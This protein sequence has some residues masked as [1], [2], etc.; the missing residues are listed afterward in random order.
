MLFKALVVFSP[1][2]WF[3]EVCSRFC[4]SDTFIYFQGKQW[5]Q[6][7]RQQQTEPAVSAGRREVAH[8]QL[9]GRVLPPAEPRPQLGAF[10][11]G[12]HVPSRG[13][14]LPHVGARRAAV[15]PRPARTP[16]PAPRLVAGTADF[17]PCGSRLVRA[18]S[19]SI[20]QK[21]RLITVSETVSNS[22]H[23]WNNTI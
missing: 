11:P 13:L 14:V 20:W 7:Q 17:Q 22:P 1:G 10:A 19:D 23:I 4:W 8:V 2:L 12:E 15:G 5:K 21:E 6:Q 18:T 3:S 9:G 16:A